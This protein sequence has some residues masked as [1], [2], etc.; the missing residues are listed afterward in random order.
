MIALAGCTPAGAPSPTQVGAAAPTSTILS[1]SAT[2]TAIATGTPIP[3]QIPDM[4]TTSSISGQ[5]SITGLGIAAV[6]SSIPSVVFKDR[7]KTQNCTIDGAKIKVD[8]L[9]SADG[10]VL[11]ATAANLDDYFKLTGKPGERTGANP[12]NK[13]KVTEI[14][15]YTLRD[16]VTGDIAITLQKGVLPDGKP[17]Y[18]V[19]CQKDGN[20]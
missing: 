5:S 17:G 7:N 3:T 9:L 14:A 6:D 12:V 20:C 19:V 1:P 13:D 18:S 15:P 8:Q 4:P 2:P 16:N 10:K 11:V